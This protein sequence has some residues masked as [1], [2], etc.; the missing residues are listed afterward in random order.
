MALLA[1]ERRILL[2]SCR[3]DRAV[4][5]MAQGAVLGRRRMLPQERPALLRVA[6]VA[7]LIHRRFDQHAGAGRSMRTMAVAASHL[8]EAHRMRGRLGE[9]RPFLAVAFVAD[10]RLCCHR[11]HGV[12]L[13]VYLVAIV[14]GNVVAVVRARMPAGAGIALMA[15]QA[16]LV[17]LFRRQEGR[18][19]ETVDAIRPAAGLGVLLARAVAGLA[20][21]TREG[22]ALVGAVGMLG[23]E[24]REH[25]KIAAV[26]VAHQT[27]VGAGFGVFRAHAGRRRGRLGCLVGW[28]VGCSGTERKA[29]QQ[30]RKHQFLDNHRRLSVSHGSCRSPIPARTESR[31]HFT[32]WTVL[33]S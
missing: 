33:T 14:A 12:A 5:V 3:I 21:Q 20:L 16:E 10:L 1:Q 31:F 6:G 7:G 18:G 13:R 19:L 4:R 32:S 23:L 15:L 30:H 8:A 9:V 25:R 26:D 22:S 28:L 17:A 11:E 24:N 2:Q 27:G 29:G